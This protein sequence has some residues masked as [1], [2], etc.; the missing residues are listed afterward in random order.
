MEDLMGREVSVSM[1]RMTAQRDVMEE[2]SQRMRELQLMGGSEGGKMPTEIVEIVREA[3]HRFWLGE[4]I[5]NPDYIGF[6][7]SLHETLAG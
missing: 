2:L 5:F 7:C 6:L 3:N 1:D 4:N